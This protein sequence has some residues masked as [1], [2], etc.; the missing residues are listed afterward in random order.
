MKHT[1]S[2]KMRS[3]LSEFLKD[4]GM[5]FPRESRIRLKEKGYK[6]LC[7]MVD[8]RDNN[9]CILCGSYTGL[10]HHHVRFRSNYG[11]DIEENL[12]LLCYRCHD[13]Y[14]HGKNE[15]SY[16]AMFEEYL[17]LERCEEWRKSHMEEL[18]SI[19]RRYKKC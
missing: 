9:H 15:K 11:S 13:I 19:Y 17:H 7:Q 10:Q 2:R 14:A 1:L 6:L 8:E 12:V 16:R 18:L 5:E 4:K 3:Y